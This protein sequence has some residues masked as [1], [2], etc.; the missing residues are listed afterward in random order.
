M[1]R[2]PFVI[3]AA[4][5]PVAF[6]MQ[7]V[8]AR[9][10]E[11]V[12]DSATAVGQLAYV[13][14]SGALDLVTV[15]ADGTIG[16]PE[17]IGPVTT[18]PKGGTVTVFGPV[19]S[20]GGG[21]VAWSEDVQAGSSYSSWIVLRQHGDGAPEKINTTKTEAAPIGFVGQQLV[22]SNFDGKAWV[23]KP[24]THPQLN[25][26][27]SSRQDSTFYGTDRAGVVYE[28]GFALPGKP[29]HIDLLNLNGRSTTLHTFPGS[30]F[31]GEHAPLEQGWVDPDGKDAVFEQ[32]DHTDFG[33]VGPISEA[34][35]ISGVHASAAVRLGHP[36]AA[37]PIR[38]MAGTS[39]AGDTPYSVWA[40]T[41]A[42]VPAGSVYSDDGHGWQLYAGNS[43][44]VAG[45]RTGDVITQPAKYVS[46]GVE[47]PAYDIKPTGN[48]VLHI[49]GTTETVPIQ[50]TAMVWLD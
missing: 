26:I 33:G 1:R 12:T 44:V 21:W 17:T 8:S 45:N 42:R 39:F 13:T 5:L 6:L 34:F 22:V 49:D 7:P 14:A 30:M 2:V 38:R 15:A 24:G 37:T 16:S 9:P 25:L 47:A 40:T 43:L 4:A 35:A 50:A 27:A 19:A 18:A 31:K 28:R 11:S 3:V 10:A 29:E 36:G 48:A 32:G 41:D 23:V 46:V 20:T